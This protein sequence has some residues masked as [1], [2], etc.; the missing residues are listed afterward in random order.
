MVLKLNVPSIA[1]HMAMDT[2]M[3]MDMVT[4]MVTGMVT[5]IVMGMDQVITRMMMTLH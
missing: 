4:G 3:D 5:E 2:G 1:M